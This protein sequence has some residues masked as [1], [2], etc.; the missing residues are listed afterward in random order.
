MKKDDKPYSILV[1][2]DNLGDYVILEEYLSEYLINL[3]AT[4]VESFKEAT[5]L[6][7]R[8]NNFDLVFLDL[9]LPD[10]SGE[11]LVLEITKRV[12]GIPVVVLTGFADLEFGSRSLALGAS[13]YLVK[14]NLSPEVV[15]KSI[16]YN[17]QRINFIS[18]LKES[19]KKYTDLF[20]LSPYPILVYD[21]ETFEILD[22]N[23]SAL[24][25][26]GY[27]RE[28]F[29]DMKILEIYAQEHLDSLPEKSFDFQDSEKIELQKR[30]RHIRKKGDLI[31]VE[32]NPA[33]VYI[34]NRDA[35][36]IVVKDITE[37]LKYIRKIEEQNQT[38]REI[39]W[40]QS[41]VVRAPL[42][43]MMGLMNLLESVEINSEDQ[44][45][46]NFIRQSAEELDQIIR[47]ISQKSENI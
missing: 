1:I 25:K 13:D 47:E 31:D 28:E 24:E 42:A 6:L 38:F 18:E 45:L 27:T 46:L 12:E 17:I 32:I 14:D 23:E 37:N 33:K 20:Q 39:A 34:R 41:H 19:K 40:I 21:L 16:L 7:E 5:E 11:D 29:L 15:Y 9:S 36:M 44:E 4:Q 3:Q 43:R 35:V 22:V 30:A 26:Y 8:E 2:E 10:K